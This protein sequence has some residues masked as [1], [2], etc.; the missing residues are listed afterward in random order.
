MLGS[1][2]CAEDEFFCSFL[3]FTRCGLYCTVV[4][5]SILCTV[6]TWEVEQN[7][8]TFPYRCAAPLPKYILYSI[9][10]V[11][12]FAELLRPITTLQ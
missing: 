10:H 1:E 6:G 4:L 8:D 7:E 3:L 9:I 11:I 5:L 12:A 2:A